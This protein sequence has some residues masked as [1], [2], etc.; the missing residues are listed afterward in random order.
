MSK[1]NINQEQYNNNEKKAFI[2]KLD[3]FKSILLDYFSGW[4]D[5]D[6]EQFMYWQYEN[7]KG[8]ISFFYMKPIAISK[9]DYYHYPSSM[10]L[11]DLLTQLTR[12]HKDDLKLKNYLPSMLELENFLDQLDTK[13]YAH[14]KDFDF[15]FDA[16]NQFFSTKGLFVKNELTRLLNQ[17]KQKVDSISIQDT[18]FGLEKKTELIESSR[19]EKK[20]G[21]Q[22]KL[23]EMDAL[24]DS[25]NVTIIFLFKATKH[26][27]FDFKKQIYNAIKVLE[28]TPFIKAVQD[29][30]FVFG[31]TLA[32]RKKGG[33]LERYRAMA[34]YVRDGALKDHILYSVDSD[35]D[36]KYKSYPIY[37][38]V[39]HELGHRY[40]HEFMIDGFDNQSIIQLYD[41]AMQPT[42]QCFLENLPKIGDPF[43]NLR[44]AWFLVRG[45]PAS[46]YLLTNIHKNTYIYTNSNG[47]HILID[48]SVILHRITCPSDY[49][50]KSA[51]EFFAEMCVLIA[52]DEVKPSQNLV[53]TK[54]LDI[55]ARE[56]I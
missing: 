52:L 32:L 45:N 10:T 21:F 16:L 3:H 2:K 7:G 38:T 15:D 33:F 31:T 34:S 22:K 1:M 23:E 43:S 9:F 20:S 5:R 50:S 17:A 4:D 40:H 26:Q 27:S 47:Q 46:D 55:V 35:G 39:I 28:R 51:N 49:A 25:Y 36:P 54:F 44:K 13:R 48:K 14:S 37:A 53:S 18:I 42:N 29:A 11:R 12:E 56:S 8:F 24:L 41:Q 19:I 6:P 30:R